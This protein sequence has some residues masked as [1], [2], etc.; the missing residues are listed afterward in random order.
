MLKKQFDALVLE[1]IDKMVEY[2]VPFEQIRIVTS[3]ESLRPAHGHTV[4][5]ASAH[6]LTIVEYDPL[7]LPNTIYVGKLS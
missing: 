3:Y 6:G 1:S 5:F 4:E 7:V 2:G